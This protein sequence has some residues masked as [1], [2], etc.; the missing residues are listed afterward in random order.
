M[1]ALKHRAA[2]LGT[3]NMPPPDVGGTKGPISLHNAI[4]EIA[5]HI[6]QLK[7][8]ANAYL[9]NPS[10]DTLHHRLESAL[11]AVEAAIIEARRRVRL[12]EGRPRP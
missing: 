1:S 8:E 7:S 10:Y 11:S 2:S 5:S 6:G 12:I 3:P 9:T 4:E